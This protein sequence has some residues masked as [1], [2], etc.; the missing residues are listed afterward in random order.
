MAMPALEDEFVLVVDD[1]NWAPVRA[2]TTRALRDGG[3][4]TLFAIEIRTTQNGGVPR[5]PLFETSEWHN[6]YFIAVC[7]KRAR[8]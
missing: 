3:I 8:T 6:G 4:E 2:G 1:W 5:G 7:R